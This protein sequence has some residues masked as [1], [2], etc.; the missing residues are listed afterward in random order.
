MQRCMAAVTEPPRRFDAS[1]RI[2][3]VDCAIAAAV[4]MPAGPAPMIAMSNRS[5]ARF[6]GVIVDIDDAPTGGIGAVVSES[7][8]ADAFV[9][10][11]HPHVVAAAVM[12][13][14]K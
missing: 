9:V 6:V 3:L 11:A 14:N 10:S 13:R 8:E 2:T 1:T 5:I 4:A 12:E 7:D